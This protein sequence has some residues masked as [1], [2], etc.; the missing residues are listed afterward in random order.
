MNDLTNDFMNEF[1]IYT[2]DNKQIIERL[3]YP[4]FIAEI[5][6]NNHASDLE[7]IEFIDKCN[8]FMQVAKV[9]REAGEF[10]H[11]QSHKYIIKPIV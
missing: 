7:N 2:K 5:T 8:D 11:N 4:C 6:F 1:K 9:M 10:L 3:T